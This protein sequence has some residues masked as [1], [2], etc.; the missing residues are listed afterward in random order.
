MQWHTPNL[1]M[2]SNNNWLINLLC[3]CHHLTGAYSPHN[4][5]LCSQIRQTHSGI[6]SRRKAKDRVIMIGLS[7]LLPRSVCV[8][9]HISF[10][11]EKHV[12]K[13]DCKWQN[14]IIITRKKKGILWTVIKTTTWIFCFHHLSRRKIH[15]AVKRNNSNFVE[16][17]AEIT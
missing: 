10:A 6:Q 1:S 8:T 14:N 2:S 12:A 17:K 9:P 11:N 4:I 15:N 16:N 5:C 7:D 3:V 13:P